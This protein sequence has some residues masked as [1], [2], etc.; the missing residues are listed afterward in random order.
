VEKIQT[1]ML[2]KLHTQRTHI[3][4]SDQKQILHVI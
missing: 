4:S 3:V 2:P 1:R